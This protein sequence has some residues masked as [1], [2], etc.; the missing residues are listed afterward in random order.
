[1]EFSSLAEGYP[2]KVIL[3]MGFGTLS[4]IK[5]LLE[6]GSVLRARNHSVVYAAFEESEKF[7]KP[8]QFRF[9]SLGSD[10]GNGNQRAQM[11]K[12]FSIRE[13]QDSIKS[14]PSSLGVVVPVFYDFIYP[15]LSRVID[16]EKPDVI[17][18]DF[19]S[20]A[21]RDVAEMKGIPLIT[22]F[23]TTDIFDIVSS[24]FI[25]S[26]MIYGS[27]T[28]DKLSFLQRFH[29]RIVTPLKKKYYF[30]STTRRM[31]QVRAKHGVP[32][33]SLL[34]GDFSTSLGLANTFEGLEAATLLPPYIK[35]VGPITSDS[36]P[37]M[38]P[39]LAVFLENHPRT[40]YI[41]FGSAVVLA[42]FDIENLLGGALDA[43]DQG[44]IDGILWGLGKTLAEDFPPTFNG[45][46]V[47]RDD[48]FADK[49]PH[50]RLLPWAPQVAIMQ[51]KHT[52]LFLSHG[53]LESTFEAL[54]SKTP[55]LC[56]PFFGDQPRNAR[57]LEDAGVG[58][59]I[60]RLTAT[61]TS[62]ANDIE[63][64]M[65]D[66]TGSIAA[67]AKRMQ[68]IAQFGSRRKTLGADAIEEYA[69]TAQA[70]RPIHPQKYGQAPCELSHL[71]MASRNMSFIKANSLDVYGA[72]SILAL[73]AI[74]ASLY[75]VAMIA[76]RL[77]NP[78]STSFT[79]K[80]Q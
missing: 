21:C 25:T 58:K 49:H 70:C 13:P 16:E 3:H 52:R 59:Y 69:Y 4:H 17:A 62:L 40:L 65:D 28:T 9:A 74:L 22:G 46:K 12:S 35:M 1:M 71:T 36:Y 80:N 8:Y 72:V 42:E 15:A 54:L 61:P 24:P 32:H 44:S 33:S 68:T 37:P 79:K 47:S 26:S 45:S 48:L 66:P 50:I 43:L 67:N 38:T 14:I 78:P 60:D 31:N 55:I 6:I 10:G 39:E 5:P 76:A 63:S 2:L 57:K 19:F 11:K 29:D 56:M 64:M 20:T 73:T 23:Q 7:N 53:G 75:T 41:A 27:I 77:S 30:H 18:C 51:H 34:F